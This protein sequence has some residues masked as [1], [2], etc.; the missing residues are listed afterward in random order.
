MSPCLPLATV[1]FKEVNT[2][3]P[4]TITGTLSRISLDGDEDPKLNTSSEGGL[5]FSTLPGNIPPSSILVQVPKMAPS[6]GKGLNELSDPPTKKNMGLEVPGPMYLCPENSL[7]QVEYGWM[8]PPEPALE[9]D[10]MVLPRR[11]VSLK[12]FGRDEAKLNIQMDEVPHAGKGRPVPEAEA[13]PSFVSVDHINV[14]LNQ[15][16]GTVKHA[17][18]LQFKQHPTVRQILASELSERSRTMPRT[19]PGSAMKVGSLEVS[20]GA[21]RQGGSMQRSA[22]VCKRVPMVCTRAKDCTRVHKGMPGSYYYSLTVQELG[23]TT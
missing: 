12:P 15:P 10:Y 16:Y 3:N 4:A 23:V 19:V 14:N 1:L 17:Y 21:R 5:G 18:G 22:G 8:R 11:T 20:L 9:G 7:R 13:Y 2:C 6:V